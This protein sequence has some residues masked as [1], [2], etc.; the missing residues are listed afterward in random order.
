[1]LMEYMACGGAV[2]AVNTTG[3]ADIV[4]ARNAIVIDTKGEM[5]LEDSNG[6]PRA[7]WPE[8]DLDDTIDKLEW[9]YQNRDKLKQFGDQAG[10]DLASFTW[11]KTAEELRNIIH[12]TV[13]SAPAAPDGAKKSPRTRGSGPDLDSVQAGNSI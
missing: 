11:R 9:A 3:H 10:T 6:V 1:M 4:N 12:E 7:R 8:P 2:I 5:T 13:G